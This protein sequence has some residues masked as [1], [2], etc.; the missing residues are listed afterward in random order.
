MARRPLALAVLI[1]VLLAVTAA[2]AAAQASPPA[3]DSTPAPVAVADSV[4]L[5]AFGQR[6]N[7]WLWTAE[8][9]SL[10]AHM[11][12][13]TRGFMG[14]ATN[15]SDQIYGFVRQN[16]VEAGVVR[17]SLARQGDNYVYTRVV[18]LDASDKPWS[19]GWTYGADL[20]IVD[21]SIQPGE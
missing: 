6:L 5:L 10:W 17:E 3:A 16:G 20:A 7:D 4:Q 21:V 18:H 13:K 8:A 15:L 2:S 19:I 11:G 14:S 12:E 9:D 1:V